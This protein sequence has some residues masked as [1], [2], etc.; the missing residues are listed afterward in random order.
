MKQIAQ[1]IERFGFINPILVD[2]NGL[3]IAGHG[4]LAAAVS[5]ELPLVPLIQVSGLTDSQKRQ[6]LL[7]D[8]RIA[9]NAR[10]DF[11]KLAV[12]LQEL[13]LEGTDITTTGFEIAEADQIVL[14]HIAPEADPL[15][16]LPKPSAGPTATK[17]GDQWILE[18]HRVR[19]GDA[20]TEKDVD[21]LCGD[22]LCTMML[23]DPPYNLKVADL[24]GSRQTQASRICNGQ[25]RNDGGRIRRFSSCVY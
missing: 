4:R 16:V 21:L 8:N 23:S 17:V 9:E 12:Q 11:G 20:R 22:A 24:V 19:C 6:L 5:L 15:D 13:I 10:W 25:R 14:D 2:E 1:S 18:N 7:A 3:I